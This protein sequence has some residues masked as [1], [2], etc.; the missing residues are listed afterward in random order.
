[1]SMA[2]LYLGGKAQDCPKSVKD[3]LLAS[4]EVRWG[5]DA[6]RRIGQDRVRAPGGR[7]P[8]CPRA[9]R[10]PGRHPL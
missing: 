1:M 8:M 5:K 7:L 10:H 9:R 6:V 4:F 2:C 3:V